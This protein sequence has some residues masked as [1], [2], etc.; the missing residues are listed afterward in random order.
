MGLFTHRVIEG[1]IVAT[2]PNEL[3]SLVQALKVT[4][5]RRCGARKRSCLHTA[6]MAHYPRLAR[7]FHRD[8]L[9]A[10]Q[11]YD[12]ACVPAGDVAIVEYAPRSS[13]MHVKAVT[14][15]SFC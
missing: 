8:I 10:N 7:A 15:L 9:L 2:R 14:T 3:P 13:M 1:Y 11:A 5:P 4:G 6:G 12:T